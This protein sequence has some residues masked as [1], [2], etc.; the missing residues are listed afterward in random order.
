MQIMVE[1]NNWFIL[2][3]DSRKKR[4]KIRIMASWGL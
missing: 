1:K 3:S 4:E 2:S